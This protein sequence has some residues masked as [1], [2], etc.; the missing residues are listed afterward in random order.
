MK[1]GP[2]KSKSDDT[3]PHPAMSRSSPI[4]ERFRLSPEN[5]Y[6]VFQIGGWSLLCALKA[7]TVLLDVD[8][9]PRPTY[10]R[11][12]AVFYFFLM[13]GSHGYRWWI[14]RRNWVQLPTLQQL[15]RVMLA[16]LLISLAA[17]SF[18][19]LVLRSHLHHSLLTGYLPF[20]WAR[21]TLVGFFLMLF[22]SAI[23]FVYHHQKDFQE[24]QLKQLG[25]H[26]AL[27]EAEHRALSAQ[28]NPHFLFNSLN[29]LRSLIEEN[30]ERARTAVTELALVFRAALQTARQDLIPLRE[31]LRTVHAYLS[32]ERARHEERLRLCEEIGDG[33]LDALLPPFLLQTLVENAV[34]YGVAPRPE[35]AEIHYGAHMDPCG[36]GLILRV[37]NPGRL[38]PTP[39]STGIGVENSRLRLRLLF[40]SAAFLHL[41]C[42]G[43]DQVL[44]EVLI[45]QKPIPA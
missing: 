8:R 4:L 32:L 12:W 18:C 5:Y 16:S 23:Y 38:A 36:R 1:S 14:R 28:V 6:W 35:G 34:K 20:V 27:K 2:P 13:L 7:L 40:G 30:P 15:P 45:P 22:W 10:N 42:P 31:E 43:T 29:T 19:Y 17:T 44:A 33:T 11:Y 21:A 24:L 37:T 26:A 25:L 41:T 39:E 9:P 3:A